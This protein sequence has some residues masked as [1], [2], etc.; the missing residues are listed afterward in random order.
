MNRAER[1]EQARREQARRGAGRTGTGRKVAALGSAAALAS[2]GAGAAMVMTADVAGANAPIVVDSLVDN[3]TVDSST[4]LREAI[5]LANTTPGQDEITFS[6]TGTITLASDLPKIS[7]P[8]HI[9]GPGVSDLT[10]DG[11]GAHR[12]IWLDNIT[13][14]TNAVA[15][16]LL[17]GGNAGARLGGGIL[18]SNSDVN[19]DV[20][21]VAVA[22]SYAAYGGGG[23]AVLESSGTV[24]ISNASITAN[25]TPGGGGGA[26]FSG[27]KSGHLTVSIDHAVIGQNDA[28][29]G[30]GIAVTADASLTISDSVVT[31]NDGTYSGGVFVFNGDL[32]M[33]RV[34]VQGNTV[35]VSAG[36]GVGGGLAIASNYSGYELSIIDS[37]I[38]GN[39]APCGGGVYVNSPDVLHVAN[40]TLYGNTASNGAAIVAASGLDIVQSTITGNIATGPTVASPSEPL[41]GGVLV[42]PA[43]SYS[44]SV[45]L[46]GTILAGNNA[47]G[48]VDLA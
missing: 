9:T 38:S 5:T 34:V 1:R 30:G 35:D 37:T 20:T 46:S 22:H 39:S 28:G 27:T 45:S 40:S 4:T 24:T 14:G 11:Q 23:I 6:V 36:A 15:G 32:E 7:D 2:A 42:A 25:T 43:P 33:T 41:T 16:L 47:N 10:I 13:T 44:G 31:G 21:N 12:M 18:V 8:L 26:V 48:G 19:L 29:F 17:Y 3:A